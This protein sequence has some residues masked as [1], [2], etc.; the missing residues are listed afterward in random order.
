MKCVCLLGACEGTL[1]CSTCHVVL[2]KDVFDKL[3]NK[4]CDEELDMLDLA[5]GLT[6]TYVSAV[7][8]LFLF[9]PKWGLSFVHSLLSVFL[10]FVVSYV[11]KY[12]NRKKRS[13]MFFLLQV[14]TGMSN[15]ND[16]RP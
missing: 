16:G 3:P 14:P 2:K 1:A 7:V 12:H 4:A 6:D 5:Y 11:A 13:S 10:L 9:E 8:F 15:R